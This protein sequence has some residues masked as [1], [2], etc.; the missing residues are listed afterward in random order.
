MEPPPATH[1][2]I[3]VELVDVVV[4]NEGPRIIYAFSEP[5]HLIVCRVFKQ[6][7]PFSPA[8]HPAAQVLVLIGVLYS[9]HDF[10]QL[11]DTQL[12][13]KMEDHYTP[14]TLLLFVCIA[15]MCA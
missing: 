11:A 8:L 10:C 4:G 5:Q 3:C 1:W 9:V 14:N 13:A 12:A 6:N 15:Y 2:G 7:T